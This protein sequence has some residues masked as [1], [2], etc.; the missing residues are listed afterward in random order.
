MRK[1][2]ASVVFLAALAAVVGFAGAIE[3]DVLTIGSGLLCGGAS[4][5]VMLIS[6]HIAL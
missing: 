1:A 5:A 4:A 2:I 6:A 3:Q